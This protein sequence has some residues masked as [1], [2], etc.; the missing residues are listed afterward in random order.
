M[1]TPPVTL[2]TRRFLAA[3]LLGATILAAP[4]AAQRSDEPAPL[5]APDYLFTRTAFVNETLGGLH[6]AGIR[7]ARGMLFVHWL[8]ESGA[9]PSASFADG[10][11]PPA[12]YDAVR[13]PMARLLQASLSDTIRFSARLERWPEDASPAGAVE[14]LPRLVNWSRVR[15]IADAMLAEKEPMVRELVRVALLV[16]AR[17]EVAA[18]EVEQLSGDPVIDRYLHAWA[19]EMRFRPARAGGR[20]VSAWVVYQFSFTT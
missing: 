10:N 11:V 20:P 4:A 15:Q 9:A 6:A 13:P 8:P 3:A 1:R 7:D 2:R 19:Y 17:G 5:R 12:A 16:N 18:V 14:D